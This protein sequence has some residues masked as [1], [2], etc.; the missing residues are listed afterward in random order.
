LKESSNL[1]LPRTFL[2]SGKQ[3]SLELQARYLSLPI[4][5]SSVYPAFFRYAE[6]FQAQ[7][8]F[9]RKDGHLSPKIQAVRKREMTG[10]DCKE[11]GERD[12]YEV[13]SVLLADEVSLEAWGDESLI[14]A[15]SR[16]SESKVDALHICR[17]DKPCDGD[18]S[19]ERK[20][21]AV[22]HWAQKG[23]P[24]SAGFPPSGSRK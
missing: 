2:V 3:R 20:G 12:E 23:R 18:S 4:L 24:S 8:L 21:A 11:V 13:D 15:C 14:E 6:A 16:E 7:R 1:N 9:L 22:G 17:S 19:V 5:P 10:W